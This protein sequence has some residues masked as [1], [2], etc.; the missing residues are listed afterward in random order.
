[1][2]PANGEVLW[3]NS[4]SGQIEMPQPHGGAKRVSGVTAQG[5]L[6]ATAGAVV[7]AHGPGRPGRVCPADGTFQYYRLQENGQRGGTW[8]MAVRPVPVQRRLRFRSRHRRAQPDARAPASCCRVSG[9]VIHGAKDQLGAWSPLR[10]D[11]P[12]RTGKA[13]ARL[14]H[15]LLWEIPDVP[16]GTALLVAGGRR[17]SRRAARGSPTVDLDHGRCVWSTDV[18]DG[19]VRL[20]GRR[21]LLVR[22]HGQRR[23]PLLRC[24][25]RRANR[26]VHRPQPADVP[27]DPQ[28]AAAA[29]E[30][31]RRSGV[32]EGYCVDLGCGDGDLAL[33]LARRTQTADRGHRCGPAARGRGPPAAG[34]RGL[35]RR[36]ASPSTWAI[37]QQTRFPKSFANLVVSGRSLADGPDA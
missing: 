22:Q 9:G 21:R 12:D 10:R 4:P 26:G 34:R 35:V 11:T 19:R 2:N 23:D 25:R 32:T 14:D 7:R 1:M 18:D 17:S 24:R 33:E 37:P 29:E 6:V 20:G 15:Q 30:I 16:A 31:V 27:A 3:T 36:A 28:A 5:Y 13:V 8:V